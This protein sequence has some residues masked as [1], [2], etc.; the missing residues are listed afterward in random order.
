M[1]AIPH[2]WMLASEFKRNVL[3]GMFLLLFTVW[4]FPYSSYCFVTK[5]DHRNIFTF[6]ANWKSAMKNPLSSFGS[7]LTNGT[8]YL[9]YKGKQCLNSFPRLTRFACGENGVF[10]SFAKS[11]NTCFLITLS[12]YFL[13][14]GLLLY[15]ILVAKA[16]AKILRSYPF[17]YCCNAFRIMQSSASSLFLKSAIGLT[18]FLF[19]L[20]FCDES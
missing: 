17:P 15:A 5:D 2:Q 16:I 13:C 14:S 19:R 20:S 11:A 10:V 3:F 1:C 18:R 12:L 9:Q 8:Q 7:S 6:S 4:A